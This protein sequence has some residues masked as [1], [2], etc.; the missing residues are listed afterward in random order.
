MKRAEV[1]KSFKG[2]SSCFELADWLV[3]KKISSSVY[4]VLLKYGLDLWP[5]YFF[6]MSLISLGDLIWALRITVYL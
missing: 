4:F 3:R 5:M 2:L 1:C 6:P